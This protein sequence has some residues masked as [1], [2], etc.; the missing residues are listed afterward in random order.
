MRGILNTTGVALGLAAL[1]VLGIASLPIVL[2]ALLLV[3]AGFVTLV[4]VAGACMLI[5]GPR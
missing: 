5:G 4:V 1:G 2:C 3:V